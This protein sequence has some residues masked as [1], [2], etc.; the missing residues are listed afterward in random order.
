MQSENDKPGAEISRRKDGSYRIGDLA[1]MF[2][3]TV[4][5]VRYYEELGLLKSSDRSEGLH[6]RYPEKNVVYLKRI[7]Q[8]KS[9]GLT[10]G[11]IKEFFSLAAQDRTGEGCRSL[12]AAKYQERIAAEEKLAEQIAKRLE[13]L[14]WHLSQLQTVRDFFQCPGDQCP[15]CGFKDRCEMRIDEAGPDVSAAAGV[16]D[17]AAA[18]AQ[19]QIPEPQGAQI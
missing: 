5:T 18:A 11:E 12:L 8:L 15:G 3:L 6:R 14:R 4:R 7:G 19:D 10:L 2:G 13:D 17:A 1:S 16:A 9:Y